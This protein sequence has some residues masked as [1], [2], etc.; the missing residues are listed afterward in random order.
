MVNV[1]PLYFLYFEVLLTNTDSNPNSK[2]IEIDTRTVTQ[3]GYVLNEDGD[4]VSKDQIGGHA[5]KEHEEEQQQQHID[6][7]NQFADMFKIPPTTSSSK[8]AGTSSWRS[9]M[10]DYLQHI[11][12]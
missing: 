2:A 3:M 4:Q 12:G 7:D 5:E 10:E 1:Q 8:D 9:R 6:G 11:K